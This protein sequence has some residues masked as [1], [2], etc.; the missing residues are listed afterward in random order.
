[1]MGLWG[2]Q[3]SYALL[4]ECKMVQPYKERNLA[5]VNK[6]MYESTLKIHLYNNMKIHMYKGVFYSNFCNS[7]IMEST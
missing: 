1:M 5:I 3:N 6:V 7:K 2:N 4:M